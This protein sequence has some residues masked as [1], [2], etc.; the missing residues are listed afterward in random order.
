M[1]VPNWL[2]QSQNQGIDNTLARIARGEITRLQ[3]YTEAAEKDAAAAIR[4]MNGSKMANVRVGNWSNVPIRAGKG[5]VV[6]DGEVTIP[7]DKATVDVIREAILDVKA[8]GDPDVGRRVVKSPSNAAITMLDA[9]GVP[10][11]LMGIEI[12]DDPREPGSD[13]TLTAIVLL[14]EWASKW[15]KG[16]AAC[17]AAG[18]KTT[19]PEG[20][21]I[22]SEVLR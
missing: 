9:C 5:K 19:S 22:R 8:I 4:E 11:R 21:A 16:I 18:V 17:K 3:M 15:D 12:V 7:A 13:D 20:I 2:T 6:I 14:D 1:A 10:Y